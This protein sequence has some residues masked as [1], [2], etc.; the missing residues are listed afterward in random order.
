MKNKVKKFAKIFDLFKR[1][2]NSKL[3]LIFYDFEISVFFSILIIF[4]IKIC[5]FFVRIFATH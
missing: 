5:T 3:F 2:L 4:F 1:N